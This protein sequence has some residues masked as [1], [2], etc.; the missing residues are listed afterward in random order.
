MNYS[1]L[2]K[3]A[4]K[5]GISR[6]TLWRARKRGYFC[7]D[8][9]KREVDNDAN[10]SDDIIKSWYE[11]GLIVYYC[12]FRDYYEEKDDLVQEGVVR[13]WE[14]SGKKE[15]SVFSYKYRVCVNAMRSWLKNGF[16]RRLSDDRVEYE[17]EI[18]CLDESYLNFELWEIIRKNCDKMEIREIQLFVNGYKNTLSEGVKSKLFKLL[19]SN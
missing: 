12:M 18:D 6:T 14:L 2:K 3:I 1:E 15:F 7:V 5:Y 11:L 19:T 17:F 8:Y 13:L 4:Q 16:S 10:I 9:H